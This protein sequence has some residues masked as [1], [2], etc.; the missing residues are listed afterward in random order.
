MIPDINGIVW[1]VSNRGITSVPY[2]N[3]YEIEKGDFEPELFNVRDLGMLLKARI[4]NNGYRGSDTVKQLFKKHGF[5]S[6]KIED[7]EDYV[8]LPF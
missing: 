2:A 8:D 7:R 6:N 3:F 1:M 5:K 4:Q